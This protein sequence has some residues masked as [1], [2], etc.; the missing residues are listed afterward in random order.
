MKLSLPKLLYSYD[1]LEP[2]IDART[3]EIHY[4]KHHQGYVDK[5]NAALEKYPSL[6]NG[7]GKSEME[8]LE[9][10]LK[11][12]NSVPDDIRSAVRNQGGG[13]Y[14]HSLFWKM[15]APAS[16]GGGGEPEGELAAAVKKSFGDFK[17]LKEEFSKAAAGVFGSG[18]AWLA[19][20]GKLK[21]QNEKLTIVT[22]PSQDNPV[23]QGLRPILG[24]DVWEHAYYLKY[25]NRRPE[26]IDAWFNVVN[27]GYASALFEG[28][29]N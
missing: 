4:T 11:D 16:A 13:H 1:S 14:N 29:K 6:V 17:K 7:M 15:M 24:L 10:F 23:S 28:G 22:T 8:I 19:V 21:T 20:N 27:W 18:W 9:S 5:L 3:M 26:Y 25:Q 2:H 12:L